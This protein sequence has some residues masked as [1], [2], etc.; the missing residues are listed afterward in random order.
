MNESKQLIK[1]LIRENLNN[2]SLK[3]EI[4]DQIK[5]MGLNPNE[6]PISINGKPVYLG[7]GPNEIDESVGSKVANFFI[8]ISIVAGSLVSCKKEEVKFMYKFS[9]KDSRVDTEHLN[10]NLRG[11]S[12]FAYPKGD[13]DENFLDNEALRLELDV[14]KKLNIEIVD[15]SAELELDPNQTQWK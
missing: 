9:Y 1:K 5:A 8:A 12:F 11:T 6:V 3:K 7:Q 4:D 2:A 15:G 14:E 10:P 13:Y